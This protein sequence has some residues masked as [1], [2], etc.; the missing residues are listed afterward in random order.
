[1]APSGSANLLSSR[2]TLMGIVSG[3]PA[4]AIIADSQTQKTYFVSV[5]QPVA[6]GAMLEQILDN[7]VILNY[8]GEKIELTL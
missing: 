1:M 2:L 8:S 7:R 4:Q 3:E 6:E 5:G